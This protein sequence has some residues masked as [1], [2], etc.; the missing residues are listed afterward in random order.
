MENLKI[1]AKL[2]VSFL[3]VAL[4]ALAVGIA[5]IVAVDIE[6]RNV[7]QTSVR[8]TASVLS[9]KLMNNIR[10]QESLY[11]DAALLY[12]QGDL[13]NFRKLHADIENHAAL[14]AEYISELEQSL[15]NTECR[16]LLTIVNQEYAGFTEARESYLALLR[17]SR[18]AKDE[19]KIA[20]GQL[21]ERATAL[22][23]AG[24]Q[25]ANH[26]IMLTEEQTG[27]SGVITTMINS[28]LIFI[29]FTVVVAALLFGY[30]ISD[31]ISRP[32]NAC[33]TR[34]NK[35]LVEGDLHSPVQIFNSRD[36]GGNL[37]RMV[38]ELIVSYS[39]MISEQ[40]RILKAM[41]KGN[42]SQEHEVE[43]SGDFLPIK[44]S[45]QLLQVALSTNWNALVRKTNHMDIVAT[46]SK[47]T[48]WEY[49]PVT[50][51]LSLTTHF[52]DQFGYVPGEINEFGFNSREKSFP[53]TKWTD[54]VHPDDLSHTMRELDNYISGAS[55]SYRSELQIR[56]KSGEYV[57]VIVFGRT[58]EWSE[59][60]PS[61]IIGGIF[62]ID[63]VKKSES[64]NIAKNRF[65]ASMS[66]EIRTPMNAIIGMSELIRTDNLDSQQ[67]NFFNDIRSM[68]H[69]LLQIINDILDL[70]KIEAEKM[71]L[72]PVHFDLYKL[73][74]NVVSQNKFMAANKDLEFR[75]DF[76]DNVPRVVYG[77][78]I[79]VRQIMTNLLNNA[80]KYTHEGFIRFHVEYI[81]EAGINY[82]AIVVE[83]TGI[84]IR[85]TDF[86]KIFGTFEQL[87]S[88][89][90]R[91][92]SGTGLGLPIC[93]RLAEMMNGRIEVESIYG[94]GSV[95]TA[96]LPLPKGD[97]SLVP[98]SI[99]ES[100][101]TSKGTAKILVVD[102]NAI[103]LKVALAYLAVHNITADAA[104]SGIEAIKKATEKQY[105]LI[106]MDHMMPEM[107]GLEATAHIRAIETGGYKKIPIIALTANAF[108]GARE[109]F[110]GNGM[111]DFL[112]K[113]IN[114]ADLNNVLAKWLP[115]EMYTITQKKAQRSSPPAGLP[116][117]EKLI[118]RET[119]ITNA[120]DSETFYEQLLAD[121][122][123]NHEADP[124]KIR[125]ALEMKDYPTAQRLAHTLK[126][127]AALV[128]ATTLSSAALAMEQALNNSSSAPAPELWDTL[129]KVCDA[130]FALIDNKVPDFVEEKA[131]TGIIIDK[132]S[133]L[134]FIKRLEDLLKINSA[135]SLELLDEM[136]ELFAPAGLEYRKLASDIENFDFAEARAL[137]NG[138]KE[139][140]AA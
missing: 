109:L 65:L 48:Y 77:D 71:E 92:I 3:I 25:L 135:K 81:N 31:I 13:V 11:Y 88:Y 94:R 96:L 124:E 17:N 28:I 62:N 27:E 118:D 128:G 99:E 87:D 24:Q 83:D 52:W 60:K 72:T 51:A 53:P 29:M 66:H 84:G 103:N 123:L 112:P 131:E 56:N 6:H 35:I 67:L 16:N 125:N 95:F 64:A 127:T 15:D 85:K 42:Y 30:Y 108:S 130:V 74:N 73:F 90:N 32:I 137:L 122:R 22:N 55:D 50:D 101:V 119:G 93:K 76:D 33:I 7:R 113:P 111:N 116:P 132:I 70:S 82:I 104:G 86:E 58:V 34:I 126:S 114:A 97:A 102:D 10:E 46:L 80:I 5:G 133:I 100:L 120:A 39:N 117:P 21:T 14:F 12:Y 47:L 115:R 54:I 59:G 41:A 23:N 38:R 140:L 139:S 37:S 45:N 18:S 36:E 9:G 105:D 63:D 61:L 75:S 69:M 78:D 89:K 121:F 98:H 68:S 43:Y 136:R 106:F 49:T 91:G 107:D 129:K 44:T 40:S 2:T 8:M 79:R 19:L 20:L 57:W 138:I 1:F 4:M 110:L 134:A 26:L